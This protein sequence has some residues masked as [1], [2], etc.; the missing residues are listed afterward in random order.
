MPYSKE[1]RAE[2][3]KRK[4]EK[5]KAEQMKRNER[6][7]ARRAKR[8]SKRAL[9]KYNSTSMTLPEPATK[10]VLLGT[11]TAPIT[12]KDEAPALTL[13]QAETDEPTNV[14]GEKDIPL[15]DAREMC[16]GEVKVEEVQPTV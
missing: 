4:N 16:R 3:A 7:A 1:M 2:R 8:D 14:I 10:I 9:R 11:A 5:M 15:A 6:D 13:E 12:I